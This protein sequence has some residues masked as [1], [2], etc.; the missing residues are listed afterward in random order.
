MNTAPLSPLVIVID[1]SPFIGTWIEI[2]LRREGIKA[3]RFA[4][5][6]E[7]LRALAA[8]NASVPDFAFIG[9][10]FPRARIKSGLTLIQILR[11]KVPDLPVVI[12]ARRDR[13]LDRL[14]ARLAGAQDYL[15]KPLTTQ[16]VIAAVRKYVQH[17]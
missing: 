17:M 4:D 8:P 15:V 6:F 11:S 5:P 7:A 12:I 2:A 3:I 14:F 10:D 1:E 9:L 13:V 16:A